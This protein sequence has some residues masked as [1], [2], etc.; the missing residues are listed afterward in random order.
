MNETV[1]QFLNDSPIAEKIKLKGR[2]IVNKSKLSAGD[3]AKIYEEKQYIPAQKKED[4]CELEFGGQLLASGKIV[5]RRS[6]YYFK[7]KS[8]INKKEA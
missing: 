2:V 1:N 4:I 5:K 3:L 8:I 6:G 7:V